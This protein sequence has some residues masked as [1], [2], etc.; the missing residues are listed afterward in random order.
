ML[1]KENELG[2]TAFFMVC[3]LNK[4]QKLNFIE[5]EAERWVVKVKLKQYD[6]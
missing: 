5:L 1:E 2:G 4:Y 3:Y 6:S